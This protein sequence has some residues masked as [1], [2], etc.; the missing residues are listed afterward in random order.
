MTTATTSTPHDAV[1]K[2]FL[3]HP[4]TARDFLEIHLPACLQKLCDF[5]TLKLESE[6]FIEAD[7]RS[8]YSDVLWSLHTRDGDGYV[9]VVIE[10]QSSADPHMAFRLLRYAMTAM[11][12]H[13]DAG[14]KE[15]PLV[16]PMLFYHGNRSPYPYSLCWLDAF[17]DPVAARQLYASA[18]PL[19]DITVVPDDEI[20]T[21]RRMALLEL[22]QKY[23][24]QRDLMG[25]VEQLATL[26]L[27]GCANDTQLQAMFNYI[28]QSGDASRFNEFMQEM[29]QRIPQH[30]EKLMTIAERLRLEG[31]QEGVQQGL[32]QGKHEA[33]LRIAQ[34]MLAQGIAREMV[35]LVTGLSEEDLAVNNS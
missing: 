2:T 30:K 26:L 34:T 24:R 17:A 11:Q 5:N 14:H 22:M 3:H 19:V 25:L 23:I 13:L 12:R 15:L 33:A 21:H 6:S 29:A 16:I 32:Q 8:C 31:L 10:H 1:F 7:L 20:L 28:L 9:Y 27:T 4:E 18:F 35:L